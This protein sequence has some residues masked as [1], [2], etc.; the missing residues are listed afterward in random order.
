M[1]KAEFD[2][3]ILFMTFNRLNTTKRS[4]E[5]IKKIKPSKIFLASDG[6]RNEKENQEIK[7]VRSYLLGNIDWKCEV[8]R[9]FRNKNLGCGL[10][11]SSAIEWFFENVEQGIILED[12]CLA[13]QDFFRYCE[14]L[15]KKYKNN[16]KIM[17]ISGNNFLNTQ[18]SKDSYYFTTSPFIWGW[19][20]WKSAWK[21]YNF[22][23]YKNLNNLN[24]KKIIPNPYERKIFKVRL[25]SFNLGGARN[26]DLQWFLTLKLSKGACICPKKNLVENIGLRNSRATHT[27]ENFWDRVFL[28]K[29]RQKLKF[30]L[31]H[32]K[33]LK[34]KKFTEFERLMKDLIRVI[35]KKLF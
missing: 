9:L 4:F 34:I 13:N 32:P 15:L 35:L 30:P 29:K 18:F 1:K 11:C 21:K 28:D 3:P 8:K 24:L 7:R 5:E 26:W 12:D 23:N 31:N 2:T 19:A 33:K 16:E 6:P 17:H 27:Q 20:T 22:E 14:E 10:A 25:K